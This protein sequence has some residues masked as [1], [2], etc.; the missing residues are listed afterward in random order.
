MERWLVI[1]KEGLLGPDAGE[2]EFR[3][4]MLEH[5]DLDTRN[6][7]LVEKDGEPA[8]DHHSGGPSAAKSGLYPHGGVPGKVQEIWAQPAHEYRGAWCDLGCRL[9]RRLSYHG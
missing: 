1:C 3:R 2:P 9:S 8:R 4:S 5:P 6:I 7:V